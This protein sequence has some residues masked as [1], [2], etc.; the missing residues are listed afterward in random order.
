MSAGDHRRVPRACPRCGY[1]SDATGPAS[2]ADARSG[3]VGQ[4]GDVQICLRCGMVE[5][6]ADSGQLVPLTAA[7]W[8]ALD[9]QERHDLLD[10]EDRRRRVMGA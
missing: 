3:I 8:S 1:M 5:Q 4:P 7:D 2:P 10:L 6:F 9:A